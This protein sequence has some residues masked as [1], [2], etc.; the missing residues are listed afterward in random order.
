MIFCIGF[1]SAFKSSSNE[2]SQQTRQDVLLL[3]VLLPDWLR[4]ASRGSQYLIG[5]YEAIFCFKRQ[6][7]TGETKCGFA[8]Y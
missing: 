7:L 6:M 8:G 5:K 2:E 4:T 3:L 1:Q